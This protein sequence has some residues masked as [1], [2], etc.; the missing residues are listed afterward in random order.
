MNMIEQYSSNSELKVQKE[1]LTNL[2]INLKEGILL[3]D[4]SRKIVLT[5]QMFCNLFSIPAPPEALIGADCS[6]SAEQSKH[7]FKDP[8]KFVADIDQLLK[9]QLAVYGDILEL[10]DGHFFERDYIPTYVEGLY[11]GHLWRY[12]D[13]TLTKKEQEKL[14]TQEQNYHSIFQVCPDGIIIANPET[15]KFSYVN[16]AQCNMF[17]Y[18]VEEFMT[19]GIESIHPKEHLERIRLEFG[20]MLSGE[21][22]FVTNI[23]CL[24][25]NGEIFIADISSVIVSIDGKK[26][27]L[28]FF[29]DVTNRNRAEMEIMDLNK[30]LESK[31]IERTNSLNESRNRLAKIADCLPGVVYQFQM[32]PDGSSCFPYASEG[33]R[34]IYRVSPEAAMND[35]AC[36]FATLHPDDF[37]DVVASIKE[38]SL[39]LSIWQKEYRVKFNDGTIWWLN[40]NAIPQKQTDGSI[41]WHGFIS[42]VTNRKQV[43][44]DLEEN[45]EKYRGLSEATFEAI[46]ISEKGYCIEQNLAAQTIFGYTSEE[47]FMMKGTDW[48]VEEDRNMVMNKMIEGVFEPYEATALKKDGT[49]FP[50]ILNGKMMYYKGRTVRVT[51]LTDITERKRAE[52]ETFIAKSEAEKAY[53]AKSEFLSRMSHEL[54]TPMNSILGFAQLLNL[55]E[56]NSKQK[57]QVNHILTSGTLLLNLINEVLDISR[58]ESGMLSLSLEPIQLYAVIMEMLD[59]VNPL[60]TAQDLHIELIVSPTNLLFVKA[61]LLRLKQVL[62]NLIN[63]AIKYNIVSGSVVIKTELM[64]GDDPVNCCIRIS[65]IDTG[66]GIHSD[67]FPRLFQPFER[68]GA[69]VTGKEGT[70]LGLAVVKKLMDAM[71]GSVGLESELGEGSTFWIEL[72]CVYQQKKL[73]KNSPFEMNQGY[74]IKE[75]TGSII[76]IEDNISN[77]ELVQEILE[78]HR[79]GIRLITSIYGKQAFILAK[80][81]MPDLILLDLNLP[82]MHGSEVLDILKGSKETKSIPVVIISADAIPKQIENIIQKGANDYLSKPIDVLSFLKMIDVYIE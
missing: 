82:D 72:P 46:F 57:K 50:C 52:L 34:N 77:T 66:I 5:N 76:Y 27:L 61:D 37:E 20:S 63:N 75:K 30:N 32:F 16:D 70:G 80:E 60:L 56:L 21:K 3:E 35:A 51:S 71:G 54:R 64:N 49:T 8:V 58:I 55:D 47:A 74:I 41:L 11:S 73:D 19:M 28:G 23:E 40:G 13:I 65:V 78:A 4:A 43:E 12:R 62:L 6:M 15:T 59:V 45:R 69:D 38:S 25:K 29:R 67:D 81:H 14:I 9:N 68:I 10:T 79:P 42:D 36:V 24:K 7:L 33:I 22:D 1:I 39:D 48:I 26:Q 18:S 31:V 2:L 17:G 44:S 53:I